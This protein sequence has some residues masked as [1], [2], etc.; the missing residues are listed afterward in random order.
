MIVKTYSEKRWSKITVKKSSTR[1]VAADGKEV[2]AIS[3]QDEKLRT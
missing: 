2:L 3:F 1:E